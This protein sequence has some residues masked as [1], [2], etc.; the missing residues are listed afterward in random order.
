MPRRTPTPYALAVLLILPAALIRE[1]ALVRDLPR[2]EA[3]RRT[4][5]SLR[6]VSQRRV[7]LGMAPDW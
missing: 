1:D 7:V 3:A 6:A 4:G 5:R 2:A